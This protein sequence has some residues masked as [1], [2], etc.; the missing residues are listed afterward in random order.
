M[1]NI[2][3]K[4]KSLTK[5]AMPTMLSIFISLIIGLMILLLTSKDAGDAFKAF[6]S[7]LTFGASSGKNIGNVLFNAA[8]LILLGLG[9]AIGFKGGMFNIG[10]PGQYTFAA[11]ISLIVANKFPAIPIIHLLVAVISGILAAMLVAI[12]PAILKALFNVHEVISGIMLNYIICYLT[13]ILISPRSNLLGIYNPQSNKVID[14]FSSTGKWLGL[15][16]ILFKGSNLDI[17]III[18]VVMA[19]VMIILLN[20]TKLG[21][22]IKAVGHSPSASRGV[23]IDNYKIMII[24]FAISGALVGLASTLSYL[25]L[26][27]TALRPLAEINTFAFS[28]IYIALMGASNPLGII[29]SSLFIAF[30]R[31]GGES[32]QNYGFTTT[33]TDVIIGVI[34]FLISISA[35]IFTTVVKNKKGGNRG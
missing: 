16:S 10:T 17:G 19:V 30:I 8:P 27:S 9:V 1:L 11:I 20:K 32:M 28:G 4:T 23:G 25:A 31:K 7:L 3:K 34:I 6:F 22:Q 12:I 26:A 35:F 13:V 24:T 18:A 5:S 15:N 21:Y 2:S 14:Y 29:F 33:I